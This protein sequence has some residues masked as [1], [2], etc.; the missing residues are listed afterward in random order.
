MNNIRRH[1]Y[2]VLVII[3]MG[4][5]LIVSNAAAVENMNEFNQAY[6]QQDTSNSQSHSSLL[7]NF[8]K[9]VIVLGLLICAA[10]SI[11]K[12]F[13]R[14]VN[15]R[16]QGNWLHLVDEV[17]MGQNRGLVLCEIAGKI[18][19]LGVTDHN[20][21]LLFEINDPQLAKEI[22]ETNLQEIIERKDTVL[23]IADKLKGLFRIK[24]QPSLTGKNFHI[25]MEEQAKKQHTISQ[26]DKS[27]VI[28][29]KRSGLDE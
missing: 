21:N 5:F 23:S 14:Q 27:R 10:V 28:N 22:S 17:I 7:W 13:G 24:K 1:H 20:I 11:I 19:A 12:L 8:I 6:D 25:L 16:M 4:L 3:L 29:E 9:L 26:L 2:I 18:Y 15:S